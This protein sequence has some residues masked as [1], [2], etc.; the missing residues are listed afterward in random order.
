[1][2]LPTL[3]EALARR[4]EPTVAP[5][6]SRLRAVRMLADAGIRTGVAIA[7]VLPHLTDD[8]ATLREV[9]R[10]AADAGASFAWHGVL[11]LG[12]VT[13]EAFFG[14]LADE[15]PH[16]VDV[17]RA[18][19]GAR[20]APTTY[21]RTI[22]RRVAAAVAAQPFTPPPRLPRPAPPLTLFTP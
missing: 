4:I 14:Y 10:A 20:Y 8:P 2:S 9:V 17:Y 22:E 12:E 7:P 3:D 1:M 15:Q 11:N 5:P 19:Y 13:R 18:M 16:L 21:A 6:R